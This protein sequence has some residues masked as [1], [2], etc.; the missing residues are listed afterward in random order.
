ME[1][2]SAKQGPSPTPPPEPRNYADTQVEFIE[3]TGP[4]L[5]D[6]TQSLL[7]HRIRAAGLI[8]SVAVG[9]F[10]V[11]GL[12]FT[13]ATPLRIMH[14]FLLLLLG[15]S[16]AFL[17]KSRSLSLKQLRILELAM[18]GSVTVYLG[19]VQYLAFAQRAAGSSLPVMTLAGGNAILPFVGLM[20]IYG[21]FI[22]NDWRRASRV[23]IPIAAV[24]VLVQ[25]LV[26]LQYSESIPRALV[27][28]EALRVVALERMTE[29]AIYLLLGAA[30]AIYG[31]YIVNSLRR[32]AFEARQLG[33]YR[34]TEKIG[35]GGMGEV[36]K[37]SHR[38][39]ARPA[40]IKLIRP[41][42][43]G[44]QDT[45]EAQTILRRFEREAQATAA[46]SSPHSIILYDFGLTD[47]GTFYS[48]MEFL[49]GLDLESLV[50]R[51]GP[52][53]P[54]RVVYMLYQACQSLID[55]H[56]NGLIHRDI[57][58]AN[59]FAC[60]L[61]HL[62]DFLKVLD[63]GLVKTQAKADEAETR[64]TQGITGT[65]AYIAPEQALEGKVDE[66]SD[67]YALGCVGYWMLTGYTVFEGKTHL[68]TIFSHATTAPVPPSER[69][70]QEVP[71]ELEKLILNC[72]EKEPGNRPQSAAEM[73]SQL[74]NCQL[75]D[76][77]G[78]P[79]AAEWW[80][81]HMG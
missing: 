4:R 41:D 45:A 29:S 32:Q 47:D 49:E 40:A 48:V 56:N 63:F 23:I 10:F 53:P 80:K 66:R 25:F 60:R 18:I 65:P 26:R 7:R 9:I 16:T 19:T 46:L 33:Q 21:M 2:Q 54:A 76:E 15:G 79:Q 75:R 13:E 43:L 71:T 64:L 34:L 62:Y 57:K 59:L 37:A 72:L 20:L 5:T 36:W 67:I 24:P 12:V 77:W 28:P 30:I 70:E 27:R 81:L 8:L 1:H 44:A 73:A 11:H 68:D 17:H 58:P 6:E 3:G 51:F 78:P 69:T 74:V 52:L 61:G 42:M 22:P 31:T 39:L 35:A 14:L 55:A 50:G 38:M